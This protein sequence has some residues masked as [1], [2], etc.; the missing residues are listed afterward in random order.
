VEAK[1]TAMETK[2]RGLDSELASSVVPNPCLIGGRHCSMWRV[3]C[4][5]VRLEEH[6]ARPSTEDRFGLE[7]PLVDLLLGGDELKWTMC[8]K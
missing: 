2:E 1:F 4:E 3:S 6:D 8:E 5:V 7:D